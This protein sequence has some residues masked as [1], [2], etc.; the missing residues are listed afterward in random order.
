[1]NKL[2]DR[3]SQ[4]RRLIA[5]LA[6]PTSDQQKLQS[7]IPKL[8]LLNSAWMFLILMPV[9]VPFFQSHG[10]DMEAIYQ[11]LTIF[12][13]TIVVLEVPSGYLSDL[14]G[15][16]YT[17]VLA[18]LFQGTGFAVLAASDSFGGFVVF[19]LCNAVSVSLFS[20]TDVALIY[21]TM[22]LLEEKR[23]SQPAILARKI[24]YSQVGETVAALI[25]G[26]LAA[27]SLALPATVNAVTAWLPFIVALSLHEP[28]RP[29]MVAHQHLGNFKYICRTMFLE[30]KLLRLIVLNYV[31]LGLASYIV[32]WAFQAYWKAI[33]VPLHLFGYLWAGYNLTVALTGRIAHRIERAL[34]PVLVLVVMAWLPVVGFAGMATFASGAGILL[35]LAFLISRGLN[36]VV[37]KDALNSRV[38]AEMRA[39][40]NSITSL[41]VRLVFA[42][43]GPLMGYLIDEQGHAFAFYAFAAV[44]AILFFVLC[45]PLIRQRDL[46]RPAA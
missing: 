11:L 27:V 5:R 36:Q 37:M 31:S 39:T 42:V 23:L 46:F 44:Y 26:T 8:L 1:M 33:D 38:P 34:G 3:P 13:T 17:L 9:L 6:H 45:L 29:R 4:L 22:A 16:K 25:G 43:L 19:E 12:A 10:L 32:V 41:G 35:G 40:A 30:S 14:L 15:R 24:F 21:D 2:S 18:G 7:N 20:G 28:A